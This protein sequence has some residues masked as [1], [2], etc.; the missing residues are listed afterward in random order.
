MEQRERSRLAVAEKAAREGGSIAQQFSRQG[1]VVDTK[2]GKTDY[3]TQADRD[4]Q[5][6]I[7]DT[8]SSV[9]PDEPIIGEEGNA[10]KSV[11]ESGP[12]WVVDP[13]DGTNN[14]VRNIPLW[15][16]SVGAVID[17]EPVAACNYLPLLDELYSADVTGARRNGF[18]ISVNDR[19]DPGAATVVP[20]LW[21][22][23][24]ARDEYADATAAIVNRF[25]DMRRFGSIQVTLAM[26]AEGA[27]EGAISNVPQNPWDTIAGVYLVRQAGGTVT[28]I[29]GDRWHHGSEGIVA[30][31]GHIHESVLKATRE[32]GLESPGY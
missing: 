18:S 2:S 12:A 30:S 25:G 16:T 11:P 3:V 6:R 14:Y 10:P 5:D 26:I 8:I 22:G 13:I 32:I 7:I 27:L 4:A 23:F 29:H 31:N 24:D 17:G 19:K 28:D 15:T 21:W 20:T 9:Y 1:V